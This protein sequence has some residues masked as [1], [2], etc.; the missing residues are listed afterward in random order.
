MQTQQENLER[1]MNYVRRDGLLTAP[2]CFLTI[3]DGG[4]FPE[5][6]SANDFMARNFQLEYEACEVAEGKP[7]EFKGKDT[8]VRYMS[9][10]MMLIY[11]GK[12]DGCEHYRASQLTLR[13]ESNIKFYP[14]SLPSPSFLVITESNS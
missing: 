14:L 5:Y 6:T 1:A 8:P 7:S 9:K 13:N 3:E 2:V 11:A 4:R 12:M 10:I